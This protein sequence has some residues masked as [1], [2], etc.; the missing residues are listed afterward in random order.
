MSIRMIVVAL[1]A[2]LLGACAGPPKRDPAFATVAPRVAPAPPPANGAIY[3]PATRMAW[4]ENLRARRVGDLLTIEL[5][6]RTSGSKDANS[7]VKK[8]NNTQMAN[9]TLL[10]YKPQFGANPGGKFSLG[11]D[12]NSSSQFKGEGS[13]DQSN[14]LNGEI[15]VT[16]VDVLPNGNL[17]V[18]GEKRL[19]INRGNEY[20]RISGIVRPADI[21]AANRVES[22]R[23]A[24]PTIMY[25]GDGGVADA[26]KI[27]WL[28]RFFISAI[29]PF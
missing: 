28:A 23:L 7:E 16:V 20:V 26:S 3:N 1:S 22:T 8:S 15:T 29:S 25:T 24:D 17:V 27:G 11:F 6:E 19:T 9:P 21:D 10:G 12:L 5:V 18:R 13:A 4:F 2:L 14:S